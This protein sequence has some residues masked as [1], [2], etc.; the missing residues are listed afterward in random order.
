MRVGAQ[1]GGHNKAVLADLDAYVGG[2]F[3]HG[4]NMNFTNATCILNDKDSGYASDCGL[5]FGQHVY[6]NKVYTSSGD[7]SVCGTTL[8]KWVAE[9][10]DPG[11]TVGKWPSDQVVIDAARQMLGMTSNT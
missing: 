7:A 5:D 8:S 9:G 6:G 4:N 2:C 11:T 10:H 1:F 3:Q